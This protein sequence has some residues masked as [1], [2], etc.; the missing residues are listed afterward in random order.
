MRSIGERV[1]NTIQLM[2]M[3]LAP[4]VPLICTGSFYLSNHSVELLCLLWVQGPDDRREGFE[5]NP[6]DAHDARPSGSLNAHDARPAGS[7]NLS[8]H[9][10]ELLRLLRVQR[11]DH[12]REIF[13]HNPAVAHDAGLPKSAQGLG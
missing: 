5:H 8:N 9:S 12:R 3:M 13:T 7:L 10:V 6:A 4:P 2:L 11:P 1:V